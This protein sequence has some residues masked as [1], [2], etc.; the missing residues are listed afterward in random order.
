MEN[1][2]Q[3]SQRIE[4]GLNLTP[5]QKRSLEILQKPVLE[6]G[7]Y[8]ETQL[9]TN[10][11]L[12]VDESDAAERPE[13]VGENPDFAG[14]DF[15]DVSYSSPKSDAVAE[16]AK[17]DFLLNSQTDKPRLG[18]DLINEARMDAPS[19]RVADAFKFLVEN[20][21]S[22]GFLPVD[23]LAEAGAAG[24]SAE[25]AQSALDMLQ[26]SPPSGV[27]ARSLRECFMIQLAQKGM[28]GTLAYR[29]LEDN[30]G[31]LLKRRVDKIAQ[32][33]CRSVEDVENAIEE[34]AK[35]S[36]SPAADYA[37]E[38]PELL[39]PDVEYFKNGGVW[40]VRLTNSYI[41]KL[42][43][44]SDYR[45]M[46]ASGGLDSEAQSYVR[47]KIRDAKSLI[48][49]VHQRQTTLLRI[50]K[51]ILL[52]QRRFFEDGTLLPMTR[53]DI[54][55]DV[56]L[57][58]TTVGRAIS[59]KCADTPFGVVEFKNFFTSGLENDSGAGVSSSTVKEKIRDIVAAEDPQSPL[60][61]EKISRA[62]AAMG[63]V[64]ARRTVAKYREELGIAPKTL[65]KRF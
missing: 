44:N 54:A 41:P 48:D 34:I 25:E 1:G 45:Q 29:I 47:E 55:D 4:Q 31:L 19:G 65:R 33:Q 20:L 17:R 42:K 50:A 8:I 64:A 16:Q 9:N 53:Q 15:D 18:E 7:R 30:Y 39:I 13:S 38:E 43:I 35:L 14:E 28:S 46:V 63:F 3:N 5:A 56:G 62:L 37:D 23:I 61:D 12:E 59:G 22:R 57:H 24:F 58:A 21:D 10:P 52:R 49:A 2:L 27:G 36:T 6:L 60:S 26:S 11:L 51:A 40:D 32:L